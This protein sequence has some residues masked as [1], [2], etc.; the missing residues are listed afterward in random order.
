MQGSRNGGTLAT[1]ANL[2]FYITVDGALVAYLADKGEELL[3]IATGIGN[4]GPPI[5][6]LLDG[7]QYISLLGG[8]RAG[9][10][11]VDAPRVMTFVLD[12]KVPLP[13]S[14]R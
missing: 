6:Y 3:K 10:E 1:A 4:L 5:T 14:Q 9:G 8:V 13:G 11:P 12:G 2:V 7:R